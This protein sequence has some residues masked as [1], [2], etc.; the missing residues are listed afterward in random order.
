MLAFFKLFS[1][2]NALV[3]HF[4]CQIEKNLNV[5]LIQ[6]SG[7]RGEVS[8]SQIKLRAVMFVQSSL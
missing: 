6:P 3:E 4:Q 8:S 5:I 1:E 7:D 2:A